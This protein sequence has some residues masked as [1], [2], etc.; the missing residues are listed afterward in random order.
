[1]T[2]CTGRLLYAQLMRSK[3]T[4]LIIRGFK[5]GMFPTDVK[6]ESQVWT[7]VE[8][9]HN[10]SDKAHMLSNHSLDDNRVEKQHLALCCAVRISCAPIC[11]QGRTG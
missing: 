3:T 5:E 9:K 4:M 6:V 11:C 7:W 10:G 1:M 2:I 8:V